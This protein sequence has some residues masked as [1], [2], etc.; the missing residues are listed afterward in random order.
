MAKHLPYAAQQVRG[1]ARETPIP[2]LAI[3]RP[4][5]SVGS[6]NFLQPQ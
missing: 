2:Q 5:E 6:L 1:S 4:T 3:L